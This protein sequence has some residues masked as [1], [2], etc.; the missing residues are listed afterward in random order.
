MS[1]VHASAHPRVAKRTI[2]AY[3]TGNIGA[4]AFLGLNS[5]ILPLFLAPLGASLTLIGALTSARSAE[6]VIVAPLV[7]AWSDRAWTRVGRRKP[8][9]LVCLPLCALLVAFLPFI[10]AISSRHVEV[11]GIQINLA[12]AI[13]ALIIILFTVA[14]NAMYDPYQALMAD[15]VPVERRSRVSG[16]FQMF[17]SIGLIGFLL[18][19][20]FA[21]SF[22]VLA[23]VAAVVLLLS[24][25]PTLFAV[26]ERRELAGSG[27]SSADGAPSR[28]TGKEARAE[29]LRDRQLRLYY[30]A[31]CLVNFGRNAV[32]PFLTLFMI[33]A[34]HFTQ[35]MALR[36]VFVSL[37]VTT[38]FVW[39]FGA[40][41]D[42]LGAKRLFLFG[43][44]VQAGTSI[45][46]S[47]TRE[48]LL[49]FVSFSIGGIGTA[50]QIANA[51]PLL[52][53]LA[54]SRRVG[55]FTGVDA[56]LVS[57]TASF[58]GIVMGGLIDTFGY[59]ILFPTVA[60]LYIAAA[61]PLALL[62]VE[63]SLGERE[64]SGSLASGASAASTA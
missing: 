45:L 59:N 54:P 12:L 15:L 28:Q 57:I 38:I 8:F 7:G 64:R 19:S 20:S 55:L 60:V 36:L 50:A 42:R 25:L 34:A 51:Y 16:L 24:F 35:P 29:L 41:G 31:Q 46:T 37:L 2:L 47:V 48:P 62:Q 49:L 21:A 4:N 53:R 33:K 27:S 52:T 13:A 56:G 5:F 26:R 10:P 17:G 6:G 63:R 22:A 1:E 58:A 14:F 44:L 32:T 30:A 23:L 61:V 11:A 3:V 39:P 40:L 43:V 18:L 9:I